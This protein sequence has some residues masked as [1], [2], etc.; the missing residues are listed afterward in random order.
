LRKTLLVQSEPTN[1]FDPI[2][3]AETSS[4]SK[5][6]KVE[7][8]RLNKMFVGSGSEELEAQLKR[9]TQF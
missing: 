9:R 2:A 1:C 4:K 6:K 7:K 5:C 8:L 3:E